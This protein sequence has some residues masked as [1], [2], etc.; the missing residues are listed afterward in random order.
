MSLR[1]Q[2]RVKNLQACRRDDIDCSKNLHSAL[3]SLS[4]IGKSCIRLGDAAETAG[5]TAALA[6]KRARQ[7]P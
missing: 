1:K 6:P 7:M 4:R 3:A 5:R 2:A